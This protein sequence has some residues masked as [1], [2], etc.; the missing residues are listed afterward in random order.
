M[1]K[2]G[3][4]M[5]PF[6][7]ITF[8]LGWCTSAFAFE[9]IEADA[10]Y[11]RAIKQQIMEEFT[12]GLK[13]LKTQ[14]DGLGMTVREKDIQ[15]LQLHMYDKAL[16]IGQCVDKAITLKK[17]TSDKL[18]LDKNVKGC[19]A[20]HLRFMGW[21]KSE[22][23]QAWQR[24]TS[25]LSCDREFPPQF[26][27]TDNPP[28]DFLGLKGTYPYYTGPV[29]HIALMQCYENS[30]ERMLEKLLEKPRKP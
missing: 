6:I 9:N 24:S 11:D 1:S 14:A 29:D 4:A 27:I 10:V 17:T 26:K 12:L 18:L 5:T 25:A 3:L 16:L 7:R 21:L 8:L 20:V 28:Y 23:G 22:K 2:E 15:T 13:M 30:T 19:I